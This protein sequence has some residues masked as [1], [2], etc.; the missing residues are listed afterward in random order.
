MRR[1]SALK[2]CVWFSYPAISTLITQFFSLFT[3]DLSLKTHLKAVLISCSLTSSVLQSPS[4]CFFNVTSFVLTLTLLCLLLYC[5]V[6]FISLS[7]LHLLH[8]LC[9]M[10]ISLAC[11]LC[12]IISS[13][14]FVSSTLSSVLT[15][16]LCPHFL[17]FVFPW[18]RQLITMSLTP[19]PVFPWAV[20]FP[21]FHHNLLGHVIPLAAS[22]PPLGCLLLC[23][24]ASTAASSPPLH[25]FLAYILS[26]AVVASFPPQLLP[27]LLLLQLSSPRCCIVFSSTAIAVVVFSLVVTALSPPPLLLHSAYSCY[28]GFD[29]L[30]E[31]ER[32]LVHVYSVH[33]CSTRTS[34]V[35]RNGSGTV[36]C[37]TRTSHNPTRSPLARLVCVG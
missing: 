16:S 21:S 14:V 6:S 34:H 27:P 2:S 11:L 31:R 8:L 32:L 35:L 10:D 18:L 9:C 23:F 29:F 26:F 15:P 5:V 36:L 4:L 20:I 37:L 1:A 24:I 19:L 3:L 28:V 13:I 12:C 7:H 30:S 25:P 22:T 17:C 33:S